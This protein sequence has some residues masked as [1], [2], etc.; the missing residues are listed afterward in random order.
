MVPIPELPTSDILIDIPV[1]LL[2]ILLDTQ[3]HLKFDCFVN[4]VNSI[5]QLYDSFFSS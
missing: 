2:V 4:N 1:Y 5:G 3:N